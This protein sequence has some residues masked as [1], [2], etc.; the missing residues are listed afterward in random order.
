M[1]QIMAM[2]KPLK[3]GLRLMILLYDIEAYIQ[4]GS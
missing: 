3:C 4:S 1:H 2:T